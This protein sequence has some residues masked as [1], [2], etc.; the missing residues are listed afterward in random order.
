MLTRNLL[1]KKRNTKIVLTR[2]TF[3]NY[4]SNFATNKDMIPILDP[5]K[6]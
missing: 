1:G 6:V 4:Y 2:E 5:K 3:Q